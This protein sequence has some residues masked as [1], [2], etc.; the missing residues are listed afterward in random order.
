[1]TSNCC[2]LV[3][4]SVNASS[5]VPK[6][7][8]FDLAAGLVLERRDPVVSGIRDAVLDVARP[9]QH[10]RRALALA[11]LVSA[12]PVGPA[13]GAGGPPSMPPSPA[14]ERPRGQRRP[15][16]SAYPCAT[17][18]AS[19]ADA[20]A[21]APHGR[22]QPVAPPLPPAQLRGALRSGAAG[23]DDDDAFPDQTDRLALQR[24]RLARRGGEVLLGND[25]LAAGVEVND[26]ARVGPR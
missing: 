8:T 9:S 3:A 19:H 14:A 5:D 22:D 23:P 2:G 15:V 18:R 4:Y 13:L 25:Q 26:I 11:E 7:V 17:S 24:E 6:V 21:T 1:M 10:R 16:P 12:A 20:V